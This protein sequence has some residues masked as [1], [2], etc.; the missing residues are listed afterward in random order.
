MQ[1]SKPNAL[2]YLFSCETVR[3]SGFI[4]N[5]VQRQ[6]ISRQPVLNATLWIHFLRSRSKISSWIIMA[7]AICSRELKSKVEI[8]WGVH[9]S[10]D[11]RI[12]R[13]FW[14]T[15][16]TGE[17]D[18]LLYSNPLH[19]MPVQS[20]W[21]YV[22]VSNVSY[23]VHCWSLIFNHML[24]Y[25]DG[26]LFPYIRTSRCPSGYKVFDCTHLYF[27]LFFYKYLFILNWIRFYFH[28]T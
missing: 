14:H 12:P 23:K 18:V 6:C 21:L 10:K 27:K 17:S 9:C 20:S 11:Q 25:R 15:V 16:I 26:L 8:R 1:G 19:I 13:G 28:K 5:A 7:A 2:W 22:Y 24:W 4:N 3:G